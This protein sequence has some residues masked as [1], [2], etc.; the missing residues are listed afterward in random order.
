[1]ETISYTD[2]RNHLKE[3]IDRVGTDHT[4]VR[5]ERRGGSAAVLMAEEDYTGLQETL[6]LLGNPANAERLRQARARGEEEA[7][8]LGDA[9]DRL[10][11]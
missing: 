4:P 11:R 1:M 8:S 10:S 5:I 6:Y 2:A 9:R 3:L 7:V